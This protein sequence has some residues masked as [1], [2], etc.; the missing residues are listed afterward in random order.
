MTPDC[1]KAIASTA[2]AAEPGAS[3][4]SHM[5][6]DM[7]AMGHDMGH[8]MA[9][10]S[11]DMGAMGHHVMAGLPTWALVVA[12]V[13]ALGITVWG[14]AFGRTWFRGE[15][16]WTW[17]LTAL[18][19][20][21][22][23]IKQRPFQ[24]AFQV[25][26]VLTLI[27]ILWAGFFG[28]RVPDR[29]IATIFTWTI[30]WTLL[31]LDVVLLGRL[32]CMV[33]P[34]DAIASWFRR[35][36]FWRRTD[37]P[38]ALDLKWPKW[39]RNVYPATILF[40]G[41]TWM[42]LGYGVTM[43]P[44]ATAAMGLAMVLL[45][46]VPAM[47]FE[48]KAFCQYGCLIG[49]VVGLYSM[50]A[51]VEVRSRD[52]SICRSCKTKDCLQGN[53]RGYPCPTKQCL[54]TMDQN[55]YCTVC[56]ECFKTCP[57]DNVA[58]NVRGWSSDLQT[59]RKPKRDEAMLALV[60]LSM[61]SFH[62]FTMTPTWNRV[63]SNLMSLTGVGRLVAFSLLMT[64]ILVIP[65]ALFIGFGALTTRLGGWRRR[66]LLKPKRRW[67][68]MWKLSTAYAYPLIAVA[69]MYHLAHNAGH[70]LMEA[71]SV[72]PAIS[73]PFG[74]GDDFLGTASFVP[75]ALASMQ[76][77]WVLMITFVLIGHW[78]ATRA[79]ERAHR[80]LAIAQKRE[81]LPLRARIAISL[82]PLLVTATNLWLLAQPME[83][84]TGM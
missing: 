33:C 56:T 15:G 68:G 77:I 43:N 71:G 26:L 61:T 84:R 66:S 27:L 59:V 24:F 13:L 28:T 8:D 73:D 14:I 53:E 70:F 82:F 48:R 55:T 47:I 32:W 67:E 30:W 36:A 17:E 58:L 7:G 5:G 83:M 54:G 16:R 63:M 60:L 65:I 1:H 69:L 22:W 3:S 50:I 10:M 11:H 2:T 62:G 80:N 42:E 18:A 72:V 23:L 39:L 78:W 44:R 4:A 52:K 29:N 12:I 76:T 45:A 40:L 9:D 6:H 34:W 74:R 38:L 46:V 75:T 25:P 41:L 35:L 81:H 51:P 49:R 57:S 79:M 37:E 64:L 31:I 19:P 20:M 21:R